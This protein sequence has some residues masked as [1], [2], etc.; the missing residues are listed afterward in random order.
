M[1][2]VLKQDKLQSGKTTAQPVSFNVQDMQSRARDYLAEVQQ[3]AAE[4]LEQAR[5]EAS[6]LKAQAQQSGLQAA[7]KEIEKQIED[8]AARISEARCK[9]A[10]AASQQSLEQLNQATTQWL[11]QWRNQTVELACRIAEKLV[12]AQKDFDNELL[13]VWM[14]EAIAMMRDEREVRIMV[15]P[16]DY[17]LA[18]RFLQNMA[19]TIPH[20]GSATVLPDPTIQRGGCVVRS[21]NGQVDQQLEAQLQRLAEQLGNKESRGSCRDS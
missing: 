1:A 18:G 14:E 12:R 20:A 6:A 5:K 13:R 19:Q 7:K 16:D 8:N 4:L 10:I 11:A 9:T 21:K 3:Q 15:H 2:S 17:S